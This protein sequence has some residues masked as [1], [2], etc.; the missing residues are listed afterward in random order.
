MQWTIDP[1]EQKE[2]GQR[3]SR[4]FAWLPIVCQNND[5]D[6]IVVWLEHYWQREH[7]IGKFWRSAGP[8]FAEVCTGL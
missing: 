1:R 8:P 7:R 3:N 5:G 2:T 4:R 6:K